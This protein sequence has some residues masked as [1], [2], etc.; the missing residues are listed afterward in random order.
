MNDA[1]QKRNLSVE[2]KQRLVSFF[3]VLIR[4][5]RRERITPTAKAKKRE[6]HEA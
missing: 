4:I 1:Q 3:E 6:A 2:A 5:D